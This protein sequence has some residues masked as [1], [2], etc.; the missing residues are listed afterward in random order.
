MKP[1]LDTKI[2][3]GDKVKPLLDIEE[4]EDDDDDWQGVVGLRRTWYYRG[5]SIDRLRYKSGQTVGRE[6]WREGV[7]NL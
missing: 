3:E 2:D 4:D 5:V 7:G 6:M 1:L